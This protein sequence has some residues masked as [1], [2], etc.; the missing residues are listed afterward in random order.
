LE[1]GDWL[2]NVIWDEVDRDVMD[3]RLIMGEAFFPCP[4]SFFAYQILISHRGVKQLDNQSMRIF[5]S[6]SRISQADLLLIFN[7]V[8]S[9]TSIT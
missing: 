3:P 2:E 4:F 5:L 1:K 9:L 6:L 8:K 7:P